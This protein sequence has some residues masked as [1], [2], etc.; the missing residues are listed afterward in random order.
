[1]SLIDV[2]LDGRVFLRTR[3]AI[4]RRLG[5]LFRKVL[6]S[7]TKIDDKKIFVMTYDNKYVCNPSYIVDE[8]I[9]R[10]NPVKIVFVVKQRGAI[11]ASRFPTNVR[12]VRRG[13]VE[14]FKEQASAKVWLDNAL[15]CLWY[16]VPKKGGQV[17]FNTWHGSL[18]I[19][20]LSGN[21][22]WLNIAKRCNKETDF[23]IS[24][25]QFEEDVYRST[26][27]PNVELLKYGHAR[28]DML[29]DQVKIQEAYRKVRE[30]YGLNAEDK[31]LLY[32]PTFRDSGA[33]EYY[34]VQ[35]DQLKQ[36]LEERFGG[37]WIIL[38]RMHFKDRALHAVSEDS[39]DWL[40]DATQ[41]YNVQE[42]IAA[43][44]AGLTDYSSWA[45]DYVLTKRPL[46]LYTPDLQ[47]YDQDR[48]FYYSIF[49]TP[50]PIAFTNEELRGK[51]LD[52]DEGKYLQQVEQFLADKGCY[53]QGQAA[54]LAADKIEAVMGLSG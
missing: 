42:L 40:I 48:G 4:E 54:K 27:W 23:C 33:T 17:Y 44:D 7:R 11:D 38:S 35:F 53:E 13:T 36:S 26:F 46:F 47:D 52:F 16:S 45:Y 31:L 2:L 20:R 22:H 5:I 19:K 8:L 1:M 28:N 25:S 30:H 14:M 51:V 18:G 50:F 3:E 29:F 32:A 15:N 9:R 49:D 37:N 34:D 12:L 21:K 10:K 43:S 41:Y 6:L 24:N 39:E